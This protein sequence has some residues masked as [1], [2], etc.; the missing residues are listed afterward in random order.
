MHK[1]YLKN[2]KNNAKKSEDNIENKNAFYFRMSTTYVFF[3]W[4]LRMSS[5]YINYTC[6]H[7]AYLPGISHI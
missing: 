7:C 2:T 1:L 3:I 5:V 6:L 4:H